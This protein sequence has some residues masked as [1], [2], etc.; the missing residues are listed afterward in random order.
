MYI[1][2]GYGKSYRFNDYML[3]LILELIDIKG[4]CNLV[5]LR[6]LY[7]THIE[8]ITS[9]ERKRVVSNIQNDGKTSDFAVH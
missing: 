2:Y 6:I 3:K 4:I 1:F 8:N 5:G 9:E 7:G